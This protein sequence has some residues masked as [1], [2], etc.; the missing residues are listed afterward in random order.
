M[1]E[2]KDSLTFTVADISEA[3]DIS[4]DKVR[5]LM[6]GGWIHYV[7]IGR[8]MRVSRREMQRI[9]EEGTRKSCTQ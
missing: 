8:E 7:L 6:H 9:L 2:L 5:R 1:T 4:E 3:L